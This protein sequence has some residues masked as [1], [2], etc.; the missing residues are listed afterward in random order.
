MSEALGV[1]LKSSVPDGSAVL[2]VLV[3]AKYLDSDGQ[4]ALFQ[5]CSDGLRTWEAVGMA[6]GLLDQLRDGMR[7]MFQADDDDE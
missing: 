5:S 2:E 4:T 1:P 6:T 7:A 3:V